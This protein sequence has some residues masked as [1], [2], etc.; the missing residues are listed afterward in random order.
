MNNKRSVNQRGTDMANKKHP[1][2]RKTMHPTSITRSESTLK[3]GRK[4]RLLYSQNSIKQHTD[5]CADREFESEF[6]KQQNESNSM[7]LCSLPLGNSM[8]NL[9]FTAPEAALPNTGSPVY[10]LLLI[11]SD[12]NKHARDHLCNL[13]G[14]GFRGYLQKLTGECY[15]YWFI[16]SEQSEY[17]GKRQALYWLDE[18][19]FSCDLQQDKDA[20]TI[21]KK[22]Y[23]DRSYYGSKSAV[24]RLQQAEQDKVDADTEYQQRIGSN[25]EKIKNL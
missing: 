11:L 24:K 3:I 7:L 10:E 2:T 22:Q 21:A 12:G 5:T 8:N 15:Q 17:N 25:T 4:S 19:H 23:K 1:I 13:L 6:L 20:R 14:G 18:S 16:H 9:L